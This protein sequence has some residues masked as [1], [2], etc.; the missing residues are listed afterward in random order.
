[1]LDLV[2][3]FI[4]G[5]IRDFI[6]DYMKGHLDKAIKVLSESRH[7]EFNDIIYAIEPVEDQLTQLQEYV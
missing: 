1:M 3:G 6:S 7:T 5:L 2:R 4:R